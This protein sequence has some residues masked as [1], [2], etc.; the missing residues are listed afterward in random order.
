MSGKSL[1]RKTAKQSAK[2]IIP[3]KKMPRKVGRDVGQGKLEEQ[4]DDQEKT[5]SFLF[6]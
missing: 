5:V 1:I 3:A 6:Y 4:T 2:N